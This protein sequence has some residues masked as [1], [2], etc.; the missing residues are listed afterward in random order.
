MIPVFQNK[1]GHPEG[2]CGG[3]VVASILELP[4]AEVPPLKGEDGKWFAVLWQFAQKHG[5]QIEVYARSVLPPYAYAYV[6]GMGP[7]G[8]RHA[9]VWWGGPNGRIVHDPHPD[10]AGLVTDP[11][12]PNYI[13]LWWCVFEKSE[14][15]EA[16]DEA[17]EV[18][19]VEADEE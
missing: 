12:A 15:V 14:K 10:G 18:P 1:F 7:R 3:A 5:Y 9:C 16:V 19:D 8:W 17:E 13:S 2:N 6:S 4:L 11:E